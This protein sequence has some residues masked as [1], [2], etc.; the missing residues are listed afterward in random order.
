MSTR[1]PPDA[2][3]RP[4]SRLPISTVTKTRIRPRSEFN[5]SSDF[6]ASSYGAPLESQGKH[7]LGESLPSTRP[8]T[9]LNAKLESIRDKRRSTHSRSVSLS[10]AP[11]SLERSKCFRSWQPAMSMRSQSSMSQIG[12]RMEGETPRVLKPF[13]ENRIGALTTADERTWSCPMTRSKTSTEKSSS[14]TSS[15]AHRYDTPPYG[16]PSSTIPKHSSPLRPSPSASK[17]PVQDTLMKSDRSSTLASTVRQPV[18]PP[19]IIGSPSTRILTTLKKPARSTSRLATPST[20]R[21]PISSLSI[22]ITSPT[23]VTPRTASSFSTA[24]TMMPPPTHRGVATVSGQVD[25][26]SNVGNPTINH[27]SRS[28]TRPTSS[29]SHVNQTPSRIMRP[30]SATVEAIP[31]RKILRSIKTA[32]AI[33]KMMT[34]HSPEKAP[35]V[36]SAPK[37][38]IKMASAQVKSSS[39]DTVAEI[40]SPVAHG[41]AQA[42]SLNLKERRQTVAQHGPTTEDSTMMCDTSGDYYQKVIDPFNLKGGNKVSNDIRRRIQEAR[43]SGTLQLSKLGLSNVPDEMD[44][45]L[46]NG[47]QKCVSHSKRKSIAELTA[48]VATHNS[49]ERLDGRFPDVFSCLVSVDLRHNGLRKIPLLMN[50]LYS[51]KVLNLGANKLTNESLSVLFTISSL[52]DLDIQANRF[53][54]EIPS[55]LCNLVSLE[56]LNVNGNEFSSVGPTAFSA[57]CNLQ[58]LSIKS[59][60]LRRFPFDSIENVPIVELDLS[61]NKIS[62]SLISIDRISRFSELRVLKASHNQIKVVSDFAIILPY[63]EVLDLN[64]NMVVS[65]GML[66]LCTPSLVQL[67]ISR[68]MI[69]VLPDGITELRNLKMLDISFNL[70]THFDSSLGLI[71]SLES[72]RWDGNKFSE[73]SLAV[74]DTKDVKMRLRERYEKEM[75]A[76][77]KQDEH[78]IG[79]EFLEMAV[80]KRLTRSQSKSKPLDLSGRGYS[81]LP[82]LLVERYMP[83]QYYR[84]GTDAITELHLQRNEFSTIPDTIMSLAFA[85]SLRSIN[86]SH[87]NLGEDAFVSPISLRSL[88]ELNLSCNSINSL[89]MFVANFQLQ[90]LQK[91]D[92]SFNKVH[93]VPLNLVMAFSTLEELN[94]HENKIAEIDADA[95]KGLEKIDLSNNSIRY[96]PPELGKI[97]TI[98]TLKVHGNIFKTPRWQIVQK[99]TDALMEWLRLRLPEEDDGPEGK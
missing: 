33:E 49:I 8:S 89:I 4:H 41:T 40:S 36:Q 97:K 18:P 1:T 17:R 47:H 83:G 44:E 95:F 70:F 12:S 27:S 98:V 91:L 51:L 21:R 59:N 13:S 79:D 86:L 26:S 62:G 66:L 88:S 29:L 63:L 92:L 67:N 76:K 90:S 99:G 56:A 14:T 75:S 38:M 84:Y 3:Q 43:K 19:S 96:L 68:N 6:R 87:N 64:S 58:K 23:T 34:V 2:I 52:V 42:E 48:F 32:R 45:L 15:I 55:C 74:M 31:P 16:T 24:T 80:Q 65:L 54:G 72:L 7:R 57:L 60:K 25:A 78:D 85:D 73:R 20:I 37:R 81:D 94:L 82:D 46:E 93:H 11:T 22:A 50:K 5:L 53:D 71:D 39:F 30:L 9:T 77:E 35:P 28:V 10:A 61:Y 69:P